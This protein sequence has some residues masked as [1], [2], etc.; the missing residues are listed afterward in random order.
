MQPQKATGVRWEWIGESWQLFTQQWQPWVLMLLTMTLVI[1]AAYLPYFVLGVLASIFS[2]DG[3]SSIISALFM[4]YT[5]AFGVFLICAIPWMLGGLYNAAFKQLRGEKLVVKDLFSGRPYFVSILVAGLLI[6]I[7]Y[8]IGVIMLVIPGLIVLGLTFLTIPLIVEGGRSAVDAIKESIEVTKQDWL[9][10]TLFALALQF[11]A[12]AGGIACGIGALATMPLLY[13][14]HAVAYRD[15]VG[16]RGAQRRESFMPPPPPDYRSYSP[17]PMSTPQAPFESPYRPAAPPQPEP[18]RPASPPPMPEPPYRPEP[19]PR[20]EPTHRPAPPPP[21][22]ESAT[23]A[24][25]HCGAT[26]NRVANFC[27]QCGNRLS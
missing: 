21:Q 8:F 3:G 24:C 7:A 14:G 6:G 19:A 25:P 12:G 1:F 17:S 27:N 4:L 2:Q 18:Y 26:L 23:R 13:L 9:M 10:F 20:P 15:M 16:V 22:P 11:L 5:L